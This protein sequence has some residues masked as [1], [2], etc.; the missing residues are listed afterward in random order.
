MDKRRCFFLRFK[1]QKL[2][3]PASNTNI[4]RAV[5][6]PI[7][8]PGLDCPFWSSSA[9]VRPVTAGLELNVVGCDILDEVG[10]MVGSGSAIDV[11]EGASVGVVGSGSA[12]LGGVGNVG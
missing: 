11:I 5:S 2:P 4:P 1:Y 12:C 8:N 9:R 7:S 10:T 6:R 3:N